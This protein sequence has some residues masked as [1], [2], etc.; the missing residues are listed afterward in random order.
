MLA[1][2]FISNPKMP[3][4]TRLTPSRARWAT[5]L[6]HLS[7]T[8]RRHDIRLKISESR[9][10]KCR[11]KKS[12]SYRA[13]QELL[14]FVVMSLYNTCCGFS[15]SNSCLNGK[16]FSLFPQIPSFSCFSHYFPKFSGPK[17]SGSSCSRVYSFLSPEDFSKRIRKVLGSVNSLI[18]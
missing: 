18:T 12:K 3:A 7:S 11:F 6:R 13:S 4:L 2:F 17:L 9:Y 5:S 14:S 8:Q 16:K 15:S 10:V 1:A